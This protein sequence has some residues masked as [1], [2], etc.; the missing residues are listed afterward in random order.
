MW[1]QTA[2]DVLRTGRHG[3]PGR[4][5]LQQGE[6]QPL[7]WARLGP[8]PRDEPG[9]PRQTRHVT[10]ASPRT[11][12]SDLTSAQQGTIWASLGLDPQPVT[13]VWG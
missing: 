11:L 7:V 3:Q 4:V 5:L 13:S 10:T 2:T 12:V 1:E 8:S 9:H 6:L